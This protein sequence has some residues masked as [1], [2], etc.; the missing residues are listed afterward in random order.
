MLIRQSCG[1]RRVE[2]TVHVHIAES[3]QEYRGSKED[4]SGKK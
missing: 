2:K 1:V 3:D 4:A